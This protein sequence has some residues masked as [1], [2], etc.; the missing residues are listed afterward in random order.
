[1]L[2]MRGTKYQRVVYE[3]VGRSEMGEELGHK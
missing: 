1:M 3:Y 2:P